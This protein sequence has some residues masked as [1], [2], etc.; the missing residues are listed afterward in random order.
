[1]T[2]MRLRLNMPITDLAYRFGVSRSTVS[3]TF[4][5]TLNILFS[6]LKPLVQ[7]PSREEL[8]ETM[9]MVFRKYFRRKITCIIDCFEIFIDRPSNMM[10]RAQTWSS[11]KH[12]NTAKY[13]IA[14]TPQG[15][16]SFISRGWGG[17]V[18]D[19]HLTANCQ[20]MDK[21]S[22]GDVILADRG[23]DIRELVALVGAEVIYPAFRKGK[24]QLSA[25]EVEETRK[26]ANVRIHVERVIGTVR[27]KYA[28]LGGAC[29]IDYVI[30]KPG[31]DHCYLD[32]IVHVCCALTN[33][34]PS[35]VP[36]D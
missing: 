4:L 25:T 8:H 19:K 30:T 3:K 23:F 28:F 2:L 27:Q 31:D 29:P 15:T 34:C 18:S 17:R 11:Y 5:E 1:M 26:I 22:H 12:H 36:F 7:W 6:A 20:F 21:I 35:V 32:K 33:M 16:V 13:L 14:V 24:E 9:P 10:A